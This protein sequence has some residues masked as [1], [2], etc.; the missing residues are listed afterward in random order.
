MY[1]HQYV[2][3]VIMLSQQDNY[4]EIFIGV[5]WPGGHGVR[6][7]EVWHKKKY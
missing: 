4:E 2:G 7:D 1:I 6:S 3:G 5:K